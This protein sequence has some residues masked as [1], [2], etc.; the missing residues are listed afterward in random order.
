V[1]TADNPPTPTTDQPT[2]VHI[3]TLAVGQRTSL[4][5][6]VGITTIPGVPALHIPGWQRPWLHGWG[7]CVVAGCWGEVDLHITLAG[8]MS[9]L[10][11]LLTPLDNEPLR[12]G[13][14]VWHGGLLR[15]CVQGEK[16]LRARLTQGEDGT[17]T[18]L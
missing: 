6:G 1:P 5:W 11:Y 7:S 2:G 16:A 15:R 9:W 8:S 17:L 13:L 14:C 3:G 18:V 10:G 12:V 4:P